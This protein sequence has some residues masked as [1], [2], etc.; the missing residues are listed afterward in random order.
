AA[1]APALEPRPA[2]TGPDHLAYVIYTSGSTGRPKGAMVVHRGIVNHMRWMDRAFPM[3]ASDA[4][5]Q[6]TPIS[7]DASVWELW[8]PLM[9]GARLVMA[10]PEG[11]RD[12]AYLVRAVAEHGITDLQLVPSAL[13]MLLL[14]PDLERATSLQRLFVGGE[15][16]RR[17]LVDRF[18]ARRAAAV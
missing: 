16:L 2:A 4:V 18:Q 12:M 10:R 3:R 9:G 14:E 11:H 6:K 17:A 13:E 8:L 7:F 1:P 5:L 15:A